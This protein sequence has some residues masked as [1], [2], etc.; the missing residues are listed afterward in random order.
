MSSHPGKF[1]TI[2]RGSF[3]SR[4][5]PPL[6][7]IWRRG[8]YCFFYLTWKTQMFLTSFNTNDGLI[9]FWATLGTSAFG[10]PI[11]LAAIISGV[12]VLIGKFIERRTKQRS[13]GEMADLIKTQNELLAKVIASTPLNVTHLNSADTQV[14]AKRALERTLRTSKPSAR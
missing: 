11:V 4:L 5:S 6:R 8:E 12:F 13:D 3:M 9:W 10:N 14:D 1:P 7:N 2:A